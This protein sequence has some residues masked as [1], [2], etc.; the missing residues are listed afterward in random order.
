MNHS[1][2]KLPT[3]WR[4]HVGAP[5]TATT[6]LQQLL[7]SNDENLLQKGVDVLP[8]S[9]TSKIIK[10]L[11]RKKPKGWK[12]LKRRIKG[13]I[14]ADQDVLVRDQFRA[15]MRNMPITVLSNECLLGFP[16]HIFLK[17]LFNGTERFHV[18]EDLPAMG[19][20]DIFLSIRS[21]DSLFI[22][23]F[24]EALKPLPDARARLDKRKQSFKDNPPSWFDLAIRIADRFPAA[25]VHVWRFEDYLKNPQLAIHALTG[26]Y[27]DRLEHIPAPSKTRSPSLRAIE[28][29]EQLDP[30]L[31]GQDRMRHVEE[32][33]LANPKQPDEKNE[34]FN[35][36][37]T[38]WL[39]AC[40]RQDLEWIRASDRLNLL[41]E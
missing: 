15:T 12:G 5:K 29:A 34:L 27:L 38:A 24:S 8:Y 3:N 26:V 14:A 37:E 25:N 40:Y 9:R 16:Q 41:Q 39:Q 33:Y 13:V 18:I 17:S 11:N 32:I 1:D 30:Q 21:L 31:K 10:S 19:K 22:S 4:V 36:E 2:P 23:A 20:L 28:L 35:D 7:E 6:H